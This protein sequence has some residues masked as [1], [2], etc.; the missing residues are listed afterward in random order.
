MTL[1][2]SIASRK[3]RVTMT[4][5]VKTIMITTMIMHTI[6]T[7]TMIMTMHTITI[8]TMMQSKAASHNGIC[9]VRKG[10]ATKAILKLCCIEC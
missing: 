10:I 1:P 3:G 6:T 7:M 9:A 5:M 8:T 4:M 2:A